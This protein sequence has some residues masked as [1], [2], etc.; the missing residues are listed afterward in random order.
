LAAAFW[1]TPQWSLR[2]AHLRLLGCRRGRR[3]VGSR[4]KRATGRWLQ[5]PATCGRS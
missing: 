3:A 1:A 2:I 4:E 5:A